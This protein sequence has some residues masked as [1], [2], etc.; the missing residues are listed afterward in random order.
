MCLLQIIKISS[1]DPL[2]SMGNLGIEGTCVSEKV[3]LQVNTLLKNHSHAKK[4]KKLIAAKYSNSLCAPGEAVGCVA[5][6]SVGEPST[7]MTL[8]T[9]HLAGSGANV[10]LGIPRLR[11]IIMTAS[12]NMKTPTMSVPFDPEI[13]K[14]RAL[15]LA[16]QFT[17]VSLMELLSHDHGIEVNEK[18]LRSTTGAWER[19]YFI[20]FKFHPAE[21]IEKSF[22]LSTRNIA[23]IIIKKFNP[24]LTKL[25]K[26]QY[27]ASNNKEK[28]TM[29]EGGILEDTP[30]VQKKKKKQEDDNEFAGI[31]DGVFG[32]RYGHKEEMPSYG[33]MDEEDKMIQNQAQMDDFI[34]L[35]NTDDESPLLGN[36]EKEYVSEVQGFSNLK[37]ERKH[38]RFTLE[39]IRVDASTVPLLMLSLV[40]KACKKTIAQC[41]NNIDEAYANEEDGRGLCLQTLGV[42]FTEIWK[43]DFVQH[44][45]LFSNDI[46][47]ILNV[48][49]VEAASK[50]ILLQIRGVFGVYGIEIDP[51]H[52]TLIADYMTFNG[53]LDQCH[54]L[55]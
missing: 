50:N 18:F 31:E 25:L 8:N 27:S 55:E 6:Q 28:L 33:D 52:L 46:W 9:F 35:D 32:S 11:E 1:Q 14:E 37:F 16:K 3:A 53:E 15:K 44:N 20:K 19:A 7:Q 48:Y 41:K 47:A 13:S 23:I 5:A 45:L 30:L 38:N 34:D 51:R 12:K 40:E 43:L 36:E 22:N 49:G 24:I 29:F 2:I 17:K 42:N 26:S 39:P 54:V 10:T 4:L 21:R